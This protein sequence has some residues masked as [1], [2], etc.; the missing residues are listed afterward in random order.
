[1]VLGGLGLLTYSMLVGNDADSTASSANGRG[2]AL[3]TSCFAYRDVNAN[4]EFDIGDR[5]YASLSVAGEGPAGSTVTQS[6]MN[7]FA[8]F[9]MLLGDDNSLVSQQ[10]T[11]RF[12]A[13]TPDGWVLTSGSALQEV[14]F[15][16]MEG[17]PVGIVAMGQCGPYGLAP[18]L[19]ISGSVEL[20][21]SDADNITVE[22]DSEDVAVEVVDG[23]YSAS[24][25]PGEWT[26]NLSGVDPGA[27]RLV[28]VVDVPVMVSDFVNLDE[29]PSPLTTEVVVGFDDFT[30]ANTIAEVPNG[31]FG[32]DW[33][34]WVAT[35]RLVYGGPGY[36]NTNQSGEFV[37]YNGSGSP[38]RISS[39][40]PF[41]F[42]G[43]YMGVA[44]PAAEDYPVTV[45]AWR[46]DELIHEDTLELATTGAIYFDADYRSITDLEIASDARW[47]V[48]ID[49][50]AFRVGS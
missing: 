45:R 17:S 39:D 29:Q 27:Q 12:E 25:G 46:G 1:M 6:N 18:E 2:N 14:A 44:W 33:S 16:E 31:Y 9:P 24:V 43:A 41:D 20:E 11:Y 13:Q 42:V 48:V 26:L 19:T 30:A 50:A 8:N 4:S 32:L 22:H 38:G 5:P 3:N 23:R 34:N 37:G 28:S 47:Q 10:G 36:V 21:G 40:E 35:H 15:A 49:D 7:G